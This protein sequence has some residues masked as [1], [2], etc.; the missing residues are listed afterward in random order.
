MGRQIEGT[1]EADARLVAA[2]GLVVF[3]ARY[4]CL[5]RAEA[6]I[7]DAPV[8]RHKDGCF[9]PMEQIRTVIPLRG[10]GSAPARRTL[11]VVKKQAGEFA[12][13]Q[14]GDIADGTHARTE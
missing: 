12:V 3:V 8:D 2:D 9:G 4:Q 1:V 11:A 5:G 13:R 10:I 6:E 14:T 7:P